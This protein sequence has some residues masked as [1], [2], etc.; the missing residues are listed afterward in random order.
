M[1]KK[2]KPPDWEASTYVDALFL[3]HNLPSVVFNTVI[4]GFVMIYFQ[5]HIG[6]VLMRF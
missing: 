2:K 6:R 4:I 5:A 1:S 3:F